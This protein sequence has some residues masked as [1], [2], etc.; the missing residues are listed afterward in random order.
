M[1]AEESL[2]PTHS[3]IARGVL[4]TCEAEERA[5]DGE[6]RGDSSRGFRYARGT[7]EGVGKDSG[8]SRNMA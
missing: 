8:D 3:H 7:E 6:E 1:I 2:S 4:L 5:L